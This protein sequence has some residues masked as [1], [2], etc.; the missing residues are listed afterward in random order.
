[1]VDRSPA[2]RRSPARYLVPLVLA[3][4]VLSTYLIVHHALRS[5]TT[6]T[7]P[8]NRPVEHSTGH[9]V[10][11][12]RTKPQTNAAVTVYIVRPGDTLSQIAQ[13]TGVSIAVLQALNPHLNPNALQ[14]GQRLRLRR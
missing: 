10:H 12:Q 9:H 5:S 3:A 4:T 1:M 7:V 2:G 6:A 8:T 13:R 11:S 14:V